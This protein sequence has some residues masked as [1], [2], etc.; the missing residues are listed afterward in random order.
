MPEDR[1]FQEY[2]GTGVFT[3]LAAW[4]LLV[5][6]GFV[7]E[8]GL[9]LHFLWALHFMKVY[10]L[11]DAGASAA[12]GS[13]GAI[14]PKTWRKYLW[15]FIDSIS[16]LESVVVRM[17]FAIYLRSIVYSSQDNQINLHALYRK[18]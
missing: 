4:N 11:Q 3:A 5:E 16:E 18:D 6:Y 1:R 17:N 2:F 14:D 12:G 9:I 15:P 10:P 7:P 13:S 8:N